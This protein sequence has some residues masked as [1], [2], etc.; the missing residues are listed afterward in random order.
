ME[1]QFLQHSL[2]WQIVRHTVTAVSKVST[3]RYFFRD[4]YGVFL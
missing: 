3:V 2:H 1:L 4:R